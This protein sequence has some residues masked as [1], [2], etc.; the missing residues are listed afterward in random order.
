MVPS[1]HH[2]TPH[3]E[4]PSQDPAPTSAED[5]AAT[6]SATNKETPPLLVLDG[7]TKT[8]P[9]LARAGAPPV[10]QALSM[11]L[12]AGTTIA[13]TGPSGSGKSTLLN[14]MGT[15]DTP[16]AGEIRL[17]GHSLRHA[18]DTERARIRNAD[19]GFVF[20]LHHLLPHLTVMENIL[21][22]CLAHASSADAP[23]THRA[24]D[25]LAEMGLADRV[26]HR[27]GQLSGGERQRVAVARALI[28]EPMLLLADEPTGSLDHA[29]AVT[30][31]DLLCRLHRTR[32]VTVVLATHDPALAARM[33]TRYRL[34]DGGLAEA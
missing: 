25:L 14:L 22:P 20:Q 17:R 30:L 11:T 23:T 3:S 7:V 34:R 32:G 10:L 5:P 31:V 28:R 4:A 21:L 24:R 27:P 1:Q 9:D 19:I 18:T 6:L 16:D 26:H 12:H 33:Q 29:N 2:A 15:L 8:Y 13:L